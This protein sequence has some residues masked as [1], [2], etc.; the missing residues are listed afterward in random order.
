MKKKFKRDWPS[1]LVVHWLG[2][3]ENKNLMTCSLCIKQN[4]N[5]F[6]KHLNAVINVNII[7][8]DKFI[9]QIDQ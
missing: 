1:K 4:K 5:N 7:F 9:T 8:C 6:F 3:D 2:Y